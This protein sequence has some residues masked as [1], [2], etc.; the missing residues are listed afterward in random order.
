MRP[1][2]HPS[3][4]SITNLPIVDVSPQEH[5]VVLAAPELLVAVAVGV[6]I[7]FITNVESAGQL[8]RGEL[9]CDVGHVRFLG[10]AVS[11]P[12]DFL[13]VIVRD[14]SFR[15]LTAQSEWDDADQVETKR[16]D[17]NKLAHQSNLMNFTVSLCI[18]SPQPFNSKVQKVRSPSL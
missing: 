6:G 2:L 11:S 10:V 13:Q 17:I 9:S 16:R 15:Q 5:R 12:T 14:F 18:P 4:V 7:G 1:S 3:I 8:A